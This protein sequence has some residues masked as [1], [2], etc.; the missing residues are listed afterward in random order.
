M[1]DL[2]RACLNELV[3]GSDADRTSVER[4]LAGQ[5]HVLLRDLLRCIAGE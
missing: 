4:L 5:L 2:S 3:F 1:V